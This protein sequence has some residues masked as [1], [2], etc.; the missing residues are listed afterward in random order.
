MESSSVTIRR[1]D[2]EGRGSCEV[3]YEV[4]FEPGM[5]VLETLRYIY[6]N[7][8][9][10]LAFNYGCRYGRCGTCAVMVN[11]RPSLIC[12][13]GSLK[14]MKIEPLYNFPVVKDLVIDRSEFDTRLNKIRPWLHRRLKPSSNPEVLDP[15]DFDD[16]RVVSRCIECLSCLTVCPVFTAG[17][18][19]Y[20]GPSL[21]VSLARHILDPRDELNRIPMAFSEGL[22]NCTECGRCQEVCPSKINIPRQVIEKVRELAFAHDMVPGYLKEVERHLKENGSTVAVMQ[23]QKTLLDELPEIAR[24]DREQARVAYFVGCYGNTFARLKDTGRSLVKVLA[25]HGVTVV[26]PKEQGC[27]GLPLIEG[28]GVKNVEELILKNIDIMEKAGV[29]TVI[30]SCAGCGKILKQYWPEVLRKARDRDLP[31]KVYDI[32]EY[33]ARQVSLDTAKLGAI[34]QKVVFHAPCTHHRGQ[35]IIAEPRE[36]LKFVPGI[37]LLEP[38]ESNCC[39]GGG[40]LRACNMELSSAVASNRAKELIKLAPDAVVTACPTCILQLAD[41]FRQAGAKNISVIHIVSFLA[42]S[43]QAGQ[44]NA[45]NA[46]SYV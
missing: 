43:Y 24:A 25:S 39:G 40:G 27:C 8:D 17:K 23:G 12:R 28:G 5:T 36:L 11:G 46:L 6:E 26:T 38:A 44:K 20:G 21:H 15:K 2:P 3:T 42:K 19:E 35:G 16:F 9:G 33:L 22:F 31:F 13:D 7:Y 18:Y 32:S 14:E 45:Q 37:K 30:T 1:Y 34:P 29:D 10:S 4:P 41:S